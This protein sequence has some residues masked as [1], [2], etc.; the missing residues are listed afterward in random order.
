MIADGKGIAAHILAT[1]KE[2]AKWLPRPPRVEAFVVGSSPATESY[3]KIKAARAMDAGCELVVTRVA[4]SVSTDELSAQVGAS[5]ADSVIVQLPLPPTLHAHEVCN[6]ILLE[7]DAD[8]LSHLAR[9][10]GVLMPPVVGAVVEI[11]A[12]SGVKVSGKRAVVVGAGYLVGEPVAAWL[13]KEGA[14]V[15]VVTRESG[16]LRDALRGADLIVTGAG[17]PHLIGPEMVHEGVV[18]IDA[19]TSE[20]G[21]AI[22]GDA[23]PACAPKCTLFTPVPG[24]VGPVAVAK[25]FENTVTLAE[26]A[27]NIL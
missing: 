5:T 25:L 17:S 3:L 4:E 8:V 7:K 12:Q 18:L 6:A 11:L 10:M 15:V 1:S 24:G 21:G 26:R 2:R 20:S 13:Q 9:T 23:D 27:T 22:V 19:G 14:E 16:E